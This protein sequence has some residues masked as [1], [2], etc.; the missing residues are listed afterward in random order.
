MNAEDPVTNEQPG[1]LGVV[2]LAWLDLGRAFYVM[3]WMVVVWIGLVL[4]AAA[5]GHEIMSR[6]MSDFAKLL[7]NYSRNAVA[8]LLFVPVAMAIHKAIVLGEIAPRYRFD[9]QDA[10]TWRFAGWSLVFFAVTAAPS[11]VPIPAD[12][13]ADNAALLACLYFLLFGMFVLVGVRL[14]TVLPAISAGAAGVQWRNELAATRGQFWRVLTI[15]VLL[16]GPIWLVESVLSYAVESLWGA[17]LI[18]VSF[19]ALVEVVTAANAARLYRWLGAPAGQP[20]RLDDPP[21]GPVTLPQP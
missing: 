17:A 9:M 12:P 19:G 10:R 11:A 13:D 3:P 6:D 5:L 20:P 7:A 14:V 18:G 4:L 2:R 8:T 1:I 16:L 21:T 15:L